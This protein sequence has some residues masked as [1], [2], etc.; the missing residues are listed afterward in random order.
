MKLIADTH[1][2]VYPFYDVGTAMRHLAANLSG[3][4]PGATRAAFLV[5]RA[6]C[7]WFAALGTGEA[8]PV[9]GFRV[10]QCGEAG[11]AILKE[12]DGEPIYVF[13]GRQ[14]VTA[15]R[16]EVLSLAATPAVEAG[17]VARDVVEEV[18]V[19]GGVPVLAW[20]PGKWFFQRGTVVRNVM[21]E[22]GPRVLVGDTSLR[23]TIWPEPALMAGAATVLAGSDPLP[24]AGE[25]RYFG[26]YASIIDCDFDYARPVAS[27]RAA[28]TSGKAE[29]TRCGQRCGVLDVVR[30]VALNARAAG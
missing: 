23:P 28:L 5:E 21:A 2:H 1:L 3:L 8:S 10:E 26:R 9:P 25:E 20:A 11:A 16:V 22:F 7:D 30:R 18:L 6:D 24:F 14:F 13:A 15:E 17:R 19:A 12:E 27:I 4:C 29:V